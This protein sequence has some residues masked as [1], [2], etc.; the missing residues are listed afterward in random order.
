MLGTVAADI[1]SLQEIHR[2]ANKP[3]E[4][5]GSLRWNF[6]ALLSEVKAGISKAV[7]A[8]DDE[9]S[10]IGFDSWGVDFGLIGGDGELIEN[11]YHYRD[12]RTNGVREKAFELMSKRAIYEN[13]GLQFLPFNTVYQLLAMRLADSTTLAKAK[14]LVFMADLFPYY[15]CGRLYGEYTLASTSQLM[16]MRS[17]RWSKDIFDG[18]ALPIGIM[19]DIVDAGTTVGRLK[20]E[21]AEELGCEQIPVISVASHDTGSAVAAVPAG[22][23]NWA[24]ISS[25]TWSLIGVEVLE[26]II[27]DKS[28]EHSFTN[29][30]GVE[31]TI[32]LLKNIMGLWLVQECRRQWQREGLEF[33]YPELTE[34]AAKARPFAAYIEP[35]CGEFLAPGDMPVRINDYLAARGGD[36]ID[37]KGQMIRTI[38]ESLAF[39]YRWAAERIE[40]I[41]GGEI[42]CLHIVGGGIQN[43]L[44]CQFAANATGKRVVTGPIEATASGNILMQ[45]KAAGQIESLAEVRAIVRNSFALKEYQPQ[46]TSLW[47]ERY[48]QIVWE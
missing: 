7:K 29:E 25:G 36:R 30:G 32:R 10:G 37:D 26:A 39:K 23:G 42:N 43:E 31:N 2:F 24:Y 6:A 8:A 34:M 11:P 45:A 5:D 27:N 19:P 33:S 13:T 44:L 15:L 47:D 18:L 48:K 46:D 21:I 9:V 1:L 17:G 16:D 35:D 20:S 28:F 40:E 38:L 41:T 12:S 4:E 3:I 14:K 22:D